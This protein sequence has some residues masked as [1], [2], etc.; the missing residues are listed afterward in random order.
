MVIL[1][2]LVYHTYKNT[3]VIKSPQIQTTKYFETR[4]PFYQTS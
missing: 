4:V 2:K 3:I 1:Y